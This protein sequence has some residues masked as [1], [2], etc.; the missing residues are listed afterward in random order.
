[1]KII[2]I[3]Q[4]IRRKPAVGSRAHTVN[5][6]LGKQQ[7]IQAPGLGYGGHEIFVGQAGCSKSKFHQLEVSG[8]G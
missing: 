7:D 8:R 3:N 6:E 4:G 1:M 2:I 5:I